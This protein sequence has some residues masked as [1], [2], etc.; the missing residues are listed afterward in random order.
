MTGGAKKGGKT[1]G[2]NCGLISLAT[3]PVSNILRAHI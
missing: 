2:T 3:A 1:V